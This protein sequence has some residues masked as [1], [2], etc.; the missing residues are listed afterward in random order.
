MNTK[1]DTYTAPVYWASYL[2]NGDDSGIDAEEKAHADHW[3]KSNSVSAVC[4]E[5]DSERFT[6]H[7]SLYDTLAKV[8]GGEV[9]DYICE[10]LGAQD[11]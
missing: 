3:L 6:W 5:D 4:I 9:C 8:S 1:F 11:Q 7:Y 10:Q 2:V